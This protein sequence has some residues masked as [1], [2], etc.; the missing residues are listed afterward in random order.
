M[1]NERSSSLICILARRERWREKLSLPDRELGCRAELFQYSLPLQ[2]SRLII[3]QSIWG[4]E[5]REEWGGVSLTICT[6]RWASSTRELLGVGKCIRTR[7]NS[8]S[9]M[10]IRS[11]RY[12]GLKVTT[13]CLRNSAFEF[14]YTYTRARVLR[15]RSTI[16]SFFGIFKRRKNENMIAIIIKL[17]FLFAE[18]FYFL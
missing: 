1:G 2:C 6:L 4:F 13:S 12:P 10:R 7:R 18:T 14:I 9:L 17:F 15:E 5:G 16:A 11:S 3:E 8:G